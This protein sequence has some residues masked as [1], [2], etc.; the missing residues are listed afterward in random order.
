MEPSRARLFRETVLVLILCSHLRVCTSTTINVSTSCLLGRQPVVFRPADRQHSHTHAIAA[1]AVAAAA[2]TAP[3]DRRWARRTLDGR[4]P[5]SVCGACS[6]CA[7]SGAV[8]SLRG[9]VTHAVCAPEP[10]LGARSPGTQE[11]HGHQPPVGQ[12]AQRGARVRQST[13]SSVFRTVVTGHRHSQ[14][15]GAL[16]PGLMSFTHLLRRPQ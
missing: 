3:A 2:A 1:A 13:G 12:L 9:V 5:T 6:S 4:G 14:C 10:V 15:T 8:C 11:P 16:R 7:Q